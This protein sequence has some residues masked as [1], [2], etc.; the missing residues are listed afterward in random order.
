MISDCLACPRVISHHAHL[1]NR[2]HIHE[3]GS[4]RGFQLMQGKIDLRLV[5]LKQHDT[6]QS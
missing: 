6:W 3:P 4:C 2:V 5:E 1:G